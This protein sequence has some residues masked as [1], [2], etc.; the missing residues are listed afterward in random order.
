MWY[1]LVFIGTC[2]EGELVLTVSAYFLLQGQLSF[3]PLV[4]AAALGAFFGDMLSFW[5]GWHYGDRLSA[6]FPRLSKTLGKVMQSLSTY[7][8]ILILVLRFQLMLRTIGFSSLGNQKPNGLKVS[9]ILFIAAWIWALVL[10]VFLKSIL[11]LLIAQYRILV[12][13]W[14]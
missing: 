13:L 10:T 14:P 9:A 8:T 11:P 4:I 5:A 6:C 7:P 3:I 1:V 2:L 12:E